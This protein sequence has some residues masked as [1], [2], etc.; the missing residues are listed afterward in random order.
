MTKKRVIKLSVAKFFVLIMGIFMLLGF[1][2]SKAEASIITRLIMDE[3]IKMEVNDEDV[4]GKFNDKIIR[5]VDS[6]DKTRYF[7]KHKNLQLYRVFDGT[8]DIYDITEPGNTTTSH[9][10]LV[11]SGKLTVT[12][13]VIDSSTAKMD[14]YTVTFYDDINK[15]KEIAKKDVV[16][17]NKVSKPT[18]P[19]KD[20]HTFIGWVDENG[21]EF[22]FNTSIQATTELYA[23]WEKKYA[24]VVVAG[25]SNAVGYD[26]SAITS[27]TEDLYK[28]NSRV[29][30]LGLYGDQNLKIIPLTETAQ[31]FQ[32]MT[33]IKAKGIQLP[34]GNLLL[35]YIPEDYEIVIIPAAFGG[36]GFT[37]TASLGTYDQVAKKPTDLK[38]G[39]KWG[40]NSA[41]Y[42]TMKGRIEHLLDLNPDNYYIGTVWAQGE[43][44]GTNPNG[45]IA[46]FEAMTNDF[47]EYFNT[48][49]P[50]RV[51]VN[52]DVEWSKNQ[53]FN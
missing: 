42:K 49:Y 33:S 20:K 21:K 46:G 1:Q 52:G 34:L 19:S 27:E 11:P 31:N 50:N 13:G 14:Y 4:S 41:Y 38:N 2:A 15:T 47:F 32:N 39:L 22:D 29:N 26:E 9:Y 6:T 10:N 48:N 5:L 23:K 35:E 12:N 36:T 37:T 8:Y 17:G 25:Q 18:T 28:V 43:H 24:I 7:T 16:K 3:H 30:Q 44:D 45:Q 53:W 40:V 51:G